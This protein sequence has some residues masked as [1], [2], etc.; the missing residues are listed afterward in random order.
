MKLIPIRELFNEP[1][2]VHLFIIG[3][4]EV[5]CPWPAR[6][7]L[8]FFDKLKLNADYHYYVAGRATGLICW[9]F[10]VKLIVVLFF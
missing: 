1:V 4:C 8:G 7:S 9:I 10:L 3:L 5:L 6:Y 2:E